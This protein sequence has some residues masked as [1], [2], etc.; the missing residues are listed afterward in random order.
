MDSQDMGV[1]FVSEAKKQGMACVTET[2]VSPP[3]SPPQNSSISQ[4]LW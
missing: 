3:P 2:A 1:V 4:N